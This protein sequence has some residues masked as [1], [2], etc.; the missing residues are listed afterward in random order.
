[1]TLSVGVLSPDSPSSSPTFLGRNNRPHTILIAM[2][3]EHIRN[4]CWKPSSSIAL[5]MICG[6]AMA[7][8]FWHTVMAAYGASVAPGKYL[9]TVENVAAE[10]KAAPKP[11]KD[12]M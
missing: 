7:P 1:M 9:D 4:V 10:R 6:V 3:A 8:I 12:N 11:V 5:P 2:V